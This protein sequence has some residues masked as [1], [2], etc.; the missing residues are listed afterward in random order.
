[1]IAKEMKKQIR[2]T[3]IFSLI[4]FL[5]A[6][7][8]NTETP[9]PL[10]TSDLVRDQRLDEFKVEEIEPIRW[11]WNAESVEL[12]Y[13]G[14]EST[15]SQFKFADQVTVT[16]L[17]IENQKLKQRVAELELRLSKLEELLTAKERS[18]R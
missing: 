9:Y 16:E 17:Q 1:L 7:V 10:G 4:A 11:T 8:A 3:S 13:E 14:N 6:A 5:G 18:S 12:T 15:L 2:I